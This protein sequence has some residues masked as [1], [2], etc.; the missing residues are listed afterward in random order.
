MKPQIM[1]AIFERVISSGWRIAANARV[2]TKPPLTMHMPVTTVTSALAFFTVQ[3]SYMVL[4]SPRRKN[5]VMY[6]MVQ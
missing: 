2:L 6:F 1:V 5:T 4:N 3:N